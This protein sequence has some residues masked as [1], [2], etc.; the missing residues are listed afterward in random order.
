MMIGGHEHNFP[1]KKNTLDSW[2]IEILEEHNR[3]SSVDTAVLN[4]TYK[5]Y[6]AVNLS[7]YVPDSRVVIKNM[8]TN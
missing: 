8:G 6:E 5:M 1:I 2:E 3:N 7:R 4:P